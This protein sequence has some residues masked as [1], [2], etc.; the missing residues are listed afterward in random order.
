VD[1]D[2]QVDVY[3]LA[4]MGDG[5]CKSLWADLVK[6]DPGSA[7]LVVSYTGEQDRT[8]DNAANIVDGVLAKSVK[9]KDFLAET[10]AILLGQATGKNVKKNKKPKNLVKSAKPP[11][12]KQYLRELANSDDPNVREAARKELGL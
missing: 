8:R 10:T 11:T 2:R 5:R 12:R 4:Q 7:R 6:N 9:P 3:R 1:F